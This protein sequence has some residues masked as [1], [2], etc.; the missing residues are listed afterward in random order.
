MQTSPAPPGMQ[1]QFEARMHAAAAAAHGMAG[2][3]T[4]ARRAPGEI[5]PA[6]PEPPTLPGQQHAFPPGPPPAPHAQHGHAFQPA[7]AHLHAAAPSPAYMPGA[8]TRQGAPPPGFGADDFRVEQIK[9]QLR[10]EVYAEVDAKLALLAQREAEA[11]R[12]FARAE[13]IAS[14]WGTGGGS[15]LFGSGYPVQGAGGGAGTSGSRPTLV[16]LPS[17]VRKNLKLPT[18]SGQPH[19]WHRFLTEFELYCEMHGYL[20]L[21]PGSHAHMHAIMVA[22]LQ[23]HPKQAYAHWRQSRPEVATFKGLRSALQ[24]RFAGESVALEAQRLITCIKQGRGSLKTVQAYVDEFQRLMDYA[25]QGAATMSQTQLVGYFINGLNDRL[26]QAL[27]RDKQFTTFDACKEHLMRI[28]VESTWPLI[29]GAA[30]E[31][32]ISAAGGPTPM[33]LGPMELQAQLDDLRTQLAALHTRSKSPAR[34]G[35]GHGGAKGKYDRGKGG[36]RD[37][38][39]SPDYPTWG[40]RDQSRLQGLHREGKCYLCSSTEHAWRACP[41]VSGRSP[42]AERGQAGRSPNGSSPRR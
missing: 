12:L 9:Q 35:S 8:P 28:Q 27:L 2:T 31:A 36:Y 1:A 42:S 20:E 3:P 38:T 5:L 23:G 16:T 18:Y 37:P 7:A 21:D 19:E 14:G 34:Q 6:L 17:E 32:A 30:A 25:N 22:C 11:R 26:T 13:D 10:A 4:V 29:G 41:K 24:Q 15:G 40:S 33:E 39:K